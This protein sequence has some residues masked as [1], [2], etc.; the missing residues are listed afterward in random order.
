MLNCRGTFQGIVLQVGHINFKRDI[1]AAPQALPNFFGTPTQLQS[2]H[3]SSILYRS[4]EAQRK[5]FSGGVHALV[6]G[7]Q[8]HRVIMM[9]EKHFDTLSQDRL[10]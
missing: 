10:L 6:R 4:F 2:L 5:S 3:F 9:L 7:Q 8:S 1:G